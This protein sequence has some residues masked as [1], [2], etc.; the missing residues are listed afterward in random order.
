MLDDLPPFTP[1]RKITLPCGASVF[2]S[3]ALVKD[4]WLQWSDVLPAEEGE[5]SLFDVEVGVNV[6]NL[7]REISLFHRTMKDFKQC[8]T[9]PFTVSRWWDPTADDGWETGKFCLFK[10]K[11]LTAT[12]LVNLIPKKSDLNLKPVSPKAPQW[13]EASASLPIFD[14]LETMPQLAHSF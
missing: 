10:F 1:I 3:K 13:V 11:G 12:E 6:L 2:S 8:D 7:A 14:Y 9:S 5:W 4:S